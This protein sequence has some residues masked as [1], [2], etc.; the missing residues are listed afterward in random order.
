MPNNVTTPTEYTVDWMPDVLKYAV[1]GT[2]GRTVLQNTSTSPRIP[3]GERWFPNTPSQIRFAMW[4][5]GSSA[6]PKTRAWVGGPIQWG[7]D[8]AIVAIIEYVDVVCYN[9]SSKWEGFQHCFQRALKGRGSSLMSR[10]S[11]T[12]PYAHIQR[13][14]S[15]LTCNR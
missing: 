12:H 1:A 14:M 8:N 11:P 9:M 4:D 5:A 2:V 6:D 3:A 10:P 7:Y 13:V 15:S